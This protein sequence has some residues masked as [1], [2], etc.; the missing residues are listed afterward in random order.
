MIGELN[1][2]CRGN[3]LDFRAGPGRFRPASGGANEALAAAIGAD[4]SRQH[5]GNRRNRAVEP[6]LAE[7]REAGQG[8]VRNGADCGHQPAM[9][10]S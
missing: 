9:G 6:K 10:R 5:A 8:I 2:P 1:K 4:R 7:H 3:D